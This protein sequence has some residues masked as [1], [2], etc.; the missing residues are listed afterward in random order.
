MNRYEVF[1]KVIEC[2]SF[3]RAA[4]E[5]GYTQSAVSQMVHTLEEELSAVL[6]LREKGGAALS[7]DG[8]QYMPYITSICSACRELRVKR[9]EMQ[10]LMDGNIRIGTFTS[11]S[12]SWLPK[13][14][15][16]FKR[17]YP[18]VHF[19]L[20][21]GDYREIE[22]W[23][24][25]GAVD[26][27]FTCYDDISGLVVTPLRRDYMLAAVPLDHP[28]AKKESVTLEEIAREPF[29][30]LDEGEWSAAMEA[31]RAQGLAPDIQYTVCDDYTVITMVEQGLGVSMLYEAVLSAGGP[32]L[33]TL[34]VTEPPTRT[35]ALACRNKR[36]LS[37]A[38]KRFVDFVLDNFKRQGA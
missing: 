15:N 5:L 14:M 24:A 17:R 19:E 27:G 7:Q 3:T 28:L 23:T 30:L 6:V 25:E 18:Y 31:F 4:S 22:R 11:V 1:V 21:Q 26:F 34:R 33:K 32:H 13:L 20:Q 16:E 2:G 37:V 29:I 38:A 9:D 12:R 10:G 36:T 35:T 8:A